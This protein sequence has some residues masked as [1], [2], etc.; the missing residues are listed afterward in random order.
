MEEL[1]DPKK[2]EHALNSFNEININNSYNNNNISKNN[3]SIYIELENIPI[4]EQLI[5]IGYN[6]IYSKR[7]VAFYHPRTI[8]EALNYFLNDGGIIQHFY[9]EDRESPENKTCFLCGERKEI[10]LGYIPENNNNNLIIENDINSKS[11]I[12]NELNKY[13]I[14]EDNNI[15]KELISNE[16]NL[17][18]NNSFNKEE[19]PI[20][21]NLFIP[22][23]RN[24]LEICGHSFCNDC[25][26]NFLSIKIEENKLT[27]IKCLN[28][29]CQEKLS[30]EF[31][32]N[33]LNSNKKLIEKYK[34][35][36]LELDIINDANKK[37]CPFPNCN[38]YAELKDIKEKYVKCQNNHIFCFLC[39][40]KPHGNKPCKDKL[41]K[42][43]IKYF[44]NNF[45]KKCP[46]CGIITEK[47]E[48]CNHITCSK[49]SYQWCW[50]CNEK[51]NV[52]HFRE[53]KCKGY[54]F[55]KPKNEEDI[56]LAFEGKITLNE[57]QRQNDLEDENQIRVA[58]R[59]LHRNNHDHYDDF[60][61]NRR[62]IELVVINRRSGNLYSKIK[63]VSYSIKILLSFVIYLLFGHLILL[64][65]PFYKLINEYI[66]NKNKFY[67]YLFKPVIKLLYLLIAL[68]NFIPQIIFN[69]IMLMIIMMYD[70]SFC[71][72][73]ERIKNILFFEYDLED[74]GMDEILSIFLVFINIEVYLYFYH[75]YYFHKASE[76]KRKIFLTTYFLI[77]FLNVFSYIQYYI[78]FGTINLI[79]HIL[80]QNDIKKVF[81]YIFEKNLIKDI[82]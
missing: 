78:F 32:I 65:K 42:S 80:N 24:K 60:R 13:I 28:Y 19:C 52:E 37:F 70:N 56:K 14:N 53:G 10:H 22:C 11:K 7:L 47:S 82:N 44:K 4:V 75:Y 59:R 73:I 76:I 39:L 67:N 8:D 72:L 62:R 79:F 17:I 63:R 20:C 23:S 69:F 64:F 15:N 51:Y 34:K 31:I 40:E 30:D 71:F 9:I 81:E 26:Y 74:Y 27:F 58:R 12:I 54:Q 48:G 2:I 46:H 21:S 36:K 77:G 6:K 55:F 25:W 68:Y 41:D 35:Y 33:L 57:S 29:E 1:E 16:N 43:L 3:I 5:E 61:F 18:S 66:N 50:L 49:C 38:S 45:V